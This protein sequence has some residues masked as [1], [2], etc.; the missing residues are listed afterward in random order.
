MLTPFKDRQP[1]KAVQPP[2]K[3]TRKNTRKLIDIGVLFRQEKGFHCRVATIMLQRRYVSAVLAATVYCTATS[4]GV[5]AAEPNPPTWPSS[6]RVFDP[7]DTDISAT[8]NAAFAKNG[9]HDP[10]N[11]GQFST[12][13]YAFLFK[14]GTYTDDVPVGF[15]TT[16]A[17]LGEAPGDV[18]FAGEKG[19]YCEE[20]DYVFSGGALDTFWRS[21]E[22]FRTQ[23]NWSNTGN[24]GML[25]AVSQAAPLRRIQVDNAL[26]LYEY[27]PPYQGAGYASGG[28]FANLEVGFGSGNTNDNHAHNSKDTRRKGTASASGL[29]GKSPPNANSVVSLG[30]QQQW[31]ARNSKVSDW[32]GGVWNVVVTGVEGAP[33]SHCGTGQGTIPITNVATTPL[34]AEKPFISIDSSGKYSLIVPSVKTDSSGTEFTT[35]TATSIPFENVYVSSPTDTADIINA[36]L[37]AGLHVVLAPAIY[38]LDAPLELSHDNQILYGLGMVT[39][40]PTKGTAVVNVG[41]VDGARI[42]GVIVQAGPVVNG[43]TSP[44]LIQFGDGTH[45]GSASNPSFMHDVFGRVGGPDGTAANPVAA[46]AIVRVASGYVIGDNMWFWRADH[47]VGGAA[48]LQHNKVNHGLV[49]TGDDVT[50]YGLAV[51]H[52]LMDLVQW[53]GER[54]ATYFFQ[55]E[56]PYTVD[57]TFG[58]NGY[59][60]YRVNDTV[61]DHAGYGIGVY[62]NFV[63]SPVDVSSAIVVPSGM[64]DKFVAP[65]TIFLNGD[66]TIQHV[67]NEKG[68]A[69]TTSSRTSYVCS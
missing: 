69:V 38:D 26:T 43:A 53:F 48:D 5:D 12:E 17:G 55:S 20:G 21:A 30:S 59:A 57:E 3:K 33:A 62:S 44:A 61:K 6:V 24:T 19:V 32:Q 39:L 67:I 2:P 23:A 35:N 34:I 29:R 52:T 45:S 65:V 40:R 10:P 46:S 42:C 60:G 49:V 11:N 8:V 51:E 41:N 14:P 16:V 4:T 28:Y 13:R 68:D 15:Y 9:G 58:T 37:S 63:N 66:G 25:W 31:F 1:P 50:M 47:T 54:G 56:L 64:E 22:N 36:K 18:I 7:S 27:E